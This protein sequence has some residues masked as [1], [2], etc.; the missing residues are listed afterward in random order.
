MSSRP[1]ICSQRKYDAAIGTRQF[2]AETY[3]VRPEAMGKDDL[4]HD[5]DVV[6]IH[7]SFPTRELAEARAKEWLER[8]D[9]AYGASY[10]QEEVLD[11]FVREDNVAEWEDVGEREEFTK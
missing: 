2:V 11:W 8:R 10:V 9:L 7:Q 4:D 6:L 3:I 1:F 5:E